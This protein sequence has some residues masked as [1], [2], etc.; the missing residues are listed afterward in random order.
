[1]FLVGSTEDAKNT[2]DSSKLSVKKPRP[3]A[4]SPNRQGPQQCQ[5]RKYINMYNAESFPTRFTEILFESHIREIKNFFSPVYVLEYKRCYT[6][7]TLSNVYSTPEMKK[8][9]L[10]SNGLILLK[11]AKCKV[12]DNTIL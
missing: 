6:F 7:I 5:V 10:F 12:T 11:A 8:C 4:A 2:P 1:M 3:K 9:T